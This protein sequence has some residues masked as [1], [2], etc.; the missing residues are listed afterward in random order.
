MV[1]ADNCWNLHIQ[2]K[3]IPPDLLF[4]D[5]LGVDCI[6]V[7]DS[8][9]CCHIYVLPAASYH[10]MHLVCWRRSTLCNPKAWMR[11]AHWQKR[12]K[13]PVLKTIVINQVLNLRYIIITRLLQDYNNYQYWRQSC[14][15]T[16]SRSFTT[17]FSW[18]SCNCWRFW[19]RQRWAQ[20]EDPNVT[21]RTHSSI[22]HE[23]EA[24][25][26]QKVG[27]KPTIHGR[28]QTI[29]DKAS[30][31]GGKTRDQSE[32]ICR[33][34]VS[35]TTTS[36]Q[37]DCRT[38]QEK[39]IY[40]GTPF[41]FTGIGTSVPWK[42]FCYTVA[43]SIFDKGWTGFCMKIFFKMQVLTCRLCFIEVGA[44]I[45]CTIPGRN[46]ANHSKSNLVKICK[47]GFCLGHKL[48]PPL[49]RWSGFVCG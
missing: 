39:R 4:L 24:S 48:Y 31:R 9:R 3:I 32:A 38:I 29:I 36:L 26:L 25:Q 5:L 35:K 22:S 8:I 46:K 19:T 44:S 37:K 30:T 18:P 13:G 42:L 27:P 23:T 49:L 10:L 43:I 40:V 41:V 1:K 2:V 16:P 15:F 33:T 20:H 11:T 28:H 21:C 34:V 45:L 14:I 17:V 12:H 47:S 6:P 7:E